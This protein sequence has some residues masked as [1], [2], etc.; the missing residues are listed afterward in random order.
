MHTHLVARSVV[1]SAVRMMIVKG[2][3]ALTLSC[4]VAAA[5]LPPVKWDG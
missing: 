2:V 4:G 5:T 1:L 3:G